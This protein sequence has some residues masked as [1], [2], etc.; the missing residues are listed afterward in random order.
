MLRK[1][2][3]WETVKNDSIVGCTFNLS[4]RNHFDGFFHHRG[5][6]CIPVVEDKQVRFS[7][8]AIGP[9]DS[10]IAALHYDWVPTFGICPTRF[11]VI[12]G[13]QPGQYIK[14]TVPIRHSIMWLLV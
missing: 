14:L 7:F 6:L 5:I 3:K 2:G 12:H 9:Q 11:M 1:F 8:N 13:T 4:K 10:S